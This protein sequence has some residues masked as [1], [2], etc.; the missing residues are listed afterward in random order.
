M[1]FDYATTMPTRT[2]TLSAATWVATPIAIP[3]NPLE[4]PNVLLRNGGSGTFE[5]V[6]DGSGADDPGVGRGGAYLDY[7]G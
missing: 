2:C 7:D 1:F 5:D 4:Q 6:S 3:A